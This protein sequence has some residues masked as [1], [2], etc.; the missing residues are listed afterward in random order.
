[1]VCE[2]T[3]SRWFLT[4]GCVQRFYLWGQGWGWGCPCTFFLCSAQPSS[5]DGPGLALQGSGWCFC[6]CVVTAPWQAPPAW[7]QAEAV[8]V[9]L[10]NGAGTLEAVIVQDWPFH[11][12]FFPFFCSIIVSPSPQNAQEKN[13]FSGKVF[14][15]RNSVVEWE[16][17]MPRGGGKLMS[18]S[19][20]S[21]RL[22]CL[23]FL[24]P[25]HPSLWNKLPS[26]LLSPE[27]RGLKAPKPLSPSSALSQG[28]VTFH[29][30]L[31]VG[32]NKCG[33]SH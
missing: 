23:C 8:L 26:N 25:H 1:M 9:Q 4:A 28:F 16:G 3:L 21:Q 17:E 20:Q 7:G 6:S 29:L 27:H 32:S 13:S 33:S 10:R 5:Q 14:S 12:L 19:S 30:Q 11:L 24:F 2:T 31:D 15:T 18:V 22:F